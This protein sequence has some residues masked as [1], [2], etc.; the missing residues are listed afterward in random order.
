MGIYQSKY[1]VGENSYG[2]KGG[3]IKRICK[4]CGNHFYVE[5]SIAKF[6][7]GIYCSMVCRNIGYSKDRAGEKGSNWQGGPTKQI[8]KTC[9]KAFFAKRSAIKIGEGKFCSRKCMGIHQ[10]KNRVGKNN[11][12][13]EGGKIKRICK[14]CNNEFE[15]TPSKIKKGFGKYCSKKCLARAQSIFF[16]GGKSARWKGGEI[17]Q[18]CLFCGKCFTIKPSRIK[19]GGGKFCSLS[20]A[21]REQRHNAKPKMTTPEIKFEEICKK[22]NL[23]FYF[24]GNGSLWIGHANPDFMHKTRKVVVEVFGDY[25]HSPL[26]NKDIMYCMTLEGRRKQLKQE[27]YSLIVLWESDLKRHDAEAFVLTILKRNKIKI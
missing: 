3:G 24:T 27:G 25:W 1:K 20:C 12:R 26:L 23:P 10:S 15:I 17:T 4:T 5:R 14:I 21:R 8:C 13:W 9:G 22:Y 18:I 6:G 19:K 11:P 16:A 2:W 7:G